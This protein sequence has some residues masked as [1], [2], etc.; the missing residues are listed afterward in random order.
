MDKIVA[1]DLE[2]AK[3]IPEGEGW[4]A[5][6]PL[7]ISCA[8]T[9][10]TDGDLRLWHGA[11]QR[12][13]FSAGRYPPQMLPAECQKLA[14]YLVE[15]QSEG[16]KVVTWNGLG[17]D[18]PVL[19][20]ECGD[21]VSFDNLRDLALDH[22]DMAFAMFCEKGFMIGLNA[23]AH[24]L[25]LEGK[26]E[27][28]HGDLAP[29]MWGQGVEAQEK[30]LEYVAQDARTTFDVYQAVQ[31]GRVLP[32]TS[33]RGRPAIW[34]P[35]QGRFLTVREALELPEPDTSWMSNPWPRSKFAGWLD[36]VKTQ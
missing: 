30:V 31:K 16:Y 29:V 33:K 10:D 13:A 36:G 9:V 24:G 15:M 35:G 4:Q 23:A 34:I 2:I 22:V 32:W 12:A 6:R 3:E 5:C 27:G 17:F 21:L 1:F 18:I 8:A 28:M 11:E 25:G 26:T 7:G 20:E 19:G 14:Q